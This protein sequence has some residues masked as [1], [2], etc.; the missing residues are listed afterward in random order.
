MVSVIIPTYK[1]PSTLTRAVDSVLQQQ[2][3][4]DYELVIVDDNSPESVERKETEQVMAKYTTNSKVKYIKQSR[5]LN[6]AVARNRGVKESQGELICFLDD[7]DIFLPMKLS[8]QVQYMNEHPE[9]GASY[10]GRINKTGSISLYYKT[11]DLTEDIL[12]LR[13]LPTTITLMFR[14]E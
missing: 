14:R 5:N 3:Y 9:F 13:F 8:K 1:S 11:G 6:G 12:T 10:T 7:D 2:G 4:Y